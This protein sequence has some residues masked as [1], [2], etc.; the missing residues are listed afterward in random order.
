MIENTLNEINE[1][2][3]EKFLNITDSKD[4]NIIVI[5][6]NDCKYCDDA[7]NTLNTIASDYELK[8]NYFN[9]ETQESEN[10]KKVKEKLEKMDYKDSF[11]TPLILITESEKILDY[12]IGVSSYEYY[13]EKL[14]ELGIIK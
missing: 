8:I 12:M 6:K 4:K 1:I 11:T 2:D 9:V 5:G 13:E 3:Y 7:L 10:F 14:M